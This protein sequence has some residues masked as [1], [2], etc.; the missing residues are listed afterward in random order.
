MA[1]S[2][3]DLLDKLQGKVEISDDEVS[4][5]ALSDDFKD[6]GSVT[7]PDSVDYLE[8]DTSVLLSYLL[9]FISKKSVTKM[10]ISRSLRITL[11]SDTSAKFE[12]CE[13][14]SLMSCVVPCRNN[15][16][17]NHKI[18]DA[19]TF[20]RVARVHKGKVYLIHRKP[21]VFVDFFGGEIYIPTFN[22]DANIY[23]SRMVSGSPT[24]QGVIKTPDLLSSIQSISPILS[25]VEISDFDY[26]FVEP[27]GIYACN[28]T[29]V[30]RIK[31][32]YFPVI[33]RRSD[34]TLIQSILAVI[35][36]A[37]LEIF[38]YDQK[39]FLTSD[40]FSYVFPKTNVQ[41]VGQYKTA[42]V[43]GS[44]SYFVNMPF[45][46][47][48]VNTLSGIPESSGVVDLV[49]GKDSLKGVFRN[50]RGDVSNFTISEKVEGITSEAIFG[51]SLKTLAVIIRVFKGDA[52]VSV[53]FINDKVVFS[54]GNKECVIITKKN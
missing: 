47:S 4:K 52:F 35:G 23:T 6:V 48:Q 30:G 2:K 18:I 33:I 40:K 45:L 20:Y 24:S 9:P 34:I 12:M 38:A 53:S 39:Y 29:V 11:M 7:L 19:E 41:F 22:L 5:E 14:V 31:Q 13:G 49:F 21:E 26:I 25:F 44:G 28:G 37:D 15:H 16:F 51:V 46:T 50:R 17:P 43:K 10:V 42:F 32:E 1:E 8:F 3:L 27:D 36:N 54:A